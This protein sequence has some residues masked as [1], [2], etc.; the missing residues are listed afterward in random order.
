M[1]AAPALAGVLAAP[2][3]GPVAAAVVAAYTAVAVWAV[4][5]RTRQR[6]QADRRAT[7]L[8]LL[9]SAAADLRA[10][11]PAQTAL[12]ELAPLA[13]PGS[14]APSAAA[15]PASVQSL[16]ARIWAAVA[17]AEATGAPAAEVLERIEVDARGDDRAAAGAAAQ[18]AGARATSWLL[19]VLPLAGLGL[20]YTIGAD[21]LPVLL[22]TPVGAA[23]AAGALLLQLGGLAWT[24]RIVRPPTVA[25]AR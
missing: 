15:V 24:G 17:L 6:Q 1:V 19:A 11:L 21:P 12:A 25:G 5:R 18:V 9:S 3:G 23:C 22:H 7:V 4:R 13:R 20:G 2:L 14:P 10:G 16:V 8:D